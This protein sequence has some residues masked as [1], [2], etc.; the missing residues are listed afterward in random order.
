LFSLWPCIRRCMWLVKTGLD[1]KLNSDTTLGI[2]IRAITLFLW[3]RRDQGKLLDFIQDKPNVRVNQ[4]IFSSNSEHFS[5]KVLY[6]SFSFYIYGRLSLYP[7]LFFIRL[8]CIFYVTSSILFIYLLFF[9]L[10]LALSCSGMLVLSQDNIT[11]DLKLWL[12]EWNEN[13]STRN[14]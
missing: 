3:Q 10:F 4:L 11:P 8:F 1:T 9:F 6:K 5:L 2:C 14:S 7:I 13:K 12:T